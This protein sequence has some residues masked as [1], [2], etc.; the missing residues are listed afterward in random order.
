MTKRC[1]HRLG[2]FL[3]RRRLSLTM[4]FSDHRKDS[5]TV[6]SES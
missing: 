3:R 1:V 6:F 4:K 2:R 5:P